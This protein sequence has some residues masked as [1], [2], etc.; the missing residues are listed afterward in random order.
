MD[1][2]RIIITII[3]VIDCIALTVV[4]LLQEGKSAGL[5][6]I[7]GAADT[8]WGKNK[9]RSVEGALEKSTKFMAIGFMVMAAVLNINF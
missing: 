9:G 8:Y 2:L 6:T 7:A 4:V 1:I 3:F 5:G